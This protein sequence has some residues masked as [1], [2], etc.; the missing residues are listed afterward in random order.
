MESSSNCAADFGFSPIQMS[1][2]A[3]GRGK[4]RA[5][6]AH[7]P[8]RAM[9]PSPPPKAAAVGVVRRCSPV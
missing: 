6:D 4:G 1:P 9:V 5:G 8:A 2:G 3:A 7:W